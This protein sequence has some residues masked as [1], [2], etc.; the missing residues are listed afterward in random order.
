[1]KRGSSSIF[2]VIEHPNLSSE[3]LMDRVIDPGEAGSA[4][5]GISSRGGRAEKKNLRITA[6]RPCHGRPAYIISLFLLLRRRHVKK[7][8]TGRFPASPIRSHGS[9]QLL[10]G[11]RFDAR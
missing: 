3:K 2:S 1:L 7:Y 8:R 10:R 4:R 11:N 6:G 5:S 9:I